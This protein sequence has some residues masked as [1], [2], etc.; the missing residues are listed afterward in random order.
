MNKMKLL[1]KFNMKL[2]IITSLLLFIII[3]GCASPSKTANMIVSDSVYSYRF[4]DEKLL[5]DNVN[6]EDVKGGKPTNPMMNSQVSNDSFYF[7]LRESL[8]NARILN[9]DGNGEF[10]LNAEIIEL[11]QPLI[12]V[13]ITIEAKVKYTLREKNTKDIIFEKI[14]FSSYTGTPSDAFIFEKSSLN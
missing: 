2:K 10:I 14:I 1:R 9:K 13:N 11:K 12:G 5:K 8:E 7:A 6:L 3:S 4:S